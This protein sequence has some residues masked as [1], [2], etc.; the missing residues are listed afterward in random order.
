MSCL[1]CRPSLS[2]E[3]CFCYARNTSFKGPKSGVCKDRQGLVVSTL[4][5]CQ[6]VPCRISAAKVADV[7]GCDT[8][9]PCRIINA[10]E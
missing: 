8:Q 3:N 1:S 6:E 7:D 9:F 10:L 2:L 4:V 5:V